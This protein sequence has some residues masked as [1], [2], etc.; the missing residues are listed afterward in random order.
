MTFKTKQMTLYSI[1]VFKCIFQYGDIQETTSD[2]VQSVTIEICHLNRSSDR[3]PVDV[4]DFEIN[5]KFK[6]HNTYT[7][8]NFVHIATNTFIDR[9]T[10]AISR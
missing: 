1:Y 5:K 8:D 3:I 2:T 7:N 9:D 6:R 4:N 10:P